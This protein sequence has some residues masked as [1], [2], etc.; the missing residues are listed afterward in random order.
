MYSWSLGVEEQFY[1]L[2]PWILIVCNRISR[3]RGLQ[4]FIFSIASVS[5]ALAQGAL[6]RHPRFAFYELPP[7]AWEFALGALISIPA[8]HLGLARM[9]ERGR[10]LVA[11]GGLVL[12]FSAILLYKD[13]TPFPGLTAMVHCVGTALFILFSNETRFARAVSL[14]SGGN[15]WPN[16]LLP[17]S[18]AWPVLVI[19]RP[20]LS[21]ELSAYERLLLLVSVFAISWLSW[22]FVERPLRSRRAAYSLKPYQWV[23]LGIGVASAFAAA[24]L[25]LHISHGFPSRVPSEPAWLTAADRDAAAFQ[26]SACLARGVDLPPVAPCLLGRKNPKPII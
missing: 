5:L 20:V 26:E 18:V 3:R 13:S 11:L 9:S 22:R 23:G 7:R 4:L 24:G 8:V 21:R 25:T 2:W 17:V 10:G 6:N 19:S 15:R 1:I 14:G 16:V 12:I